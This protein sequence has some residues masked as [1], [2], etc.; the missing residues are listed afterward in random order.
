MQSWLS[1]QEQACSRGNAGCVS[2]S[3]V[4]GLCHSVDHVVPEPESSLTEAYEKWRE[5][6]D[7]KSCCDYTLHVDITH[8]ND[9]VKQEVQSLIKE[10]GEPERFFLHSPCSS[11]TPILF[12]P[13]THLSPFSLLGAWD[14]EH[15]C[16]VI[17]APPHSKHF[18]YYITDTTYGVSTRW[19]SLS[20]LGR[21]RP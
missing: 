6:A 3:P 16:W 8:W 10:K 12:T 9:S 13:S 7:G 21:W 20:S 5:W 2:E 1:K 18:I 19:G 14:L 15:A 4:W 17:G 11:P